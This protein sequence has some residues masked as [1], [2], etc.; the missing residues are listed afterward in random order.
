MLD[1]AVAF[2]RLL[3]RAGLAAG[4]DRVVEFAR[5]LGELDATRRGDVYWAGRITLCSRREDLELY[6]KA[7]RAFWEGL[8]SKALRP[9]KTRFSVSITNDSVQAPKKS[10]ER[11]E[12]GEEAVRLRYSPV[13]VLRTKDFALYTAEE[14]DELH[15]LLADLGLSGA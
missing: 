9:P 14:F 4:T 6:D 8:D 13:D 12:K 10:V 3:R 2:G 5:A 15:K 11:N 7:F 1:A